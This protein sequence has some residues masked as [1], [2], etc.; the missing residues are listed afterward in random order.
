MVTYDGDRFKLY[1]NGNVER[2]T[3]SQALPRYDSIQDNAIGSALN[4]DGVPEGYFNGKIDEAQIWNVALTKEEIRENMHLTLTGK[5]DGL[6]SYWQMNEGSG[7]TAKDIISGN[8]GVLRNMTDEDWL[9]STVP[10][11]AGTSNTQTPGVG[12]TAPIEFT[13]TNITMDFRENGNENPI[14]V[15]KIDLSPNTNPEDVDKVFDAQYWAVNRF[16]DGDFIVDLTFQI[17]EDL[18]EDDENNPERIE[19]YHRDSNSDGNW[20]LAASATNVDSANNTATFNYIHTF[21]QF[22]LARNEEGDSG[23]EFDGG[24]DNVTVGRGGQIA[25]PPS[26]ANQIEVNLTLEFW[27]KRASTGTEQFIIGS[28]E[29]WYAG[30]DADDNFKVGFLGNNLEI[31]DACSDTDWHHWA[32]TINIGLLSQQLEVY[33]DG[34]VVGSFSDFGIYAIGIDS[35]YI[36]NRDDGGAN[37]YHGRFDELRIWLVMRTALQIRENMHLTLDGTEN[38]LIGYWPFNEGSGTIAHDIVR[39]N[40]GTLQNMGDESW[41]MSTAPIGEGTSASQIGFQ[42]QSV[43]LANVTI[44]DT[45]EPFDEAVDVTVTEILRAPNTLPLADEVLDDRYWVVNLFGEPGAFSANLAF[46]IPAGYFDADDAA[47]FILYDRNSTS[48]GDWTESIMGAS[49]IT[50]ATVTFDGITSFSQ[51]TIGATAGEPLYG[52]VSGDGNITA[53]DASLILRVVVGLLQ[54]GDP[55]YP[56]LTLDRADVTGNGVVSA[57]DAAS[58]LQ[59]SV[60]LI[61]DFPKVSSVAPDLNVKKEPELLAKAIEKL[62]RVPLD[63]EGQKV[64]ANLKSLLASLLPKKT[65]LL[66][67]FPNPFNPETWIPYQLSKDA[68]VVIEIYNVKGH[69]VRELNLGEQRAGY[70]ITKDKSAHWDGR[71]YCGEKIASGIYF[72][73]LQAGRFNAIRRMVILK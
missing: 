30:F 5:E 48:D 72:Y 44:D 33:R 35:F 1:L 40:N 12:D 68:T 29:F 15:T 73:R 59:H 61:T 65:M 8:D 47:N 24:D 20:A 9:D 2:D 27:A 17:S 34:A 51:F 64:L 58:V 49:G 18:T 22:I 71:N 25:A 57:L 28:G 67:N 36:G 4:S 70:Y 14:T 19:L 53:Y 26:L 11:G 45:P 41:V 39:G 21:G 10:L 31:E 42:N 38:G 43:T 50:D 52:D 62:E 13:G 3:L 54:L 46:T 60:G 16:G 23:V 63:K 66:Q 7:A 55:D 37:G 32:I 69:L 6:V 56:Y